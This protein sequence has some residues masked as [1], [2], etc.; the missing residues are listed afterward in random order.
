MG[1]KIYNISTMEYYPAI[2]KNEVMPFAETWMQL[3]MIILS[4]VNHKEKI[5]IAWYHLY[6]ESK[7]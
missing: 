6:V 5:N 7:V 3:E 1:R 2:N 4:Q